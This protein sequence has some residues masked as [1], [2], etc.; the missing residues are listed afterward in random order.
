MFRVWGLGS[1]LQQ[2]LPQC[3]IGVSDSPLIRTDPL[4]TV[5]GRGNNQVVG[6]S[7]IF[8]F[9]LKLVCRN[10]ILTKY[11]LGTEQCGN[12]L[13]LEHGMLLIRSHKVE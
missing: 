4:W 9:V 5:T 3:V 8:Q 1:P 6:I 13:A 2:E 11:K 7:W 10:A 12:K